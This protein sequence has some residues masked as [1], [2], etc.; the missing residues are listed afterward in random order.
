MKAAIK[1]HKILATVYD[2][3]ALLY[4]HVNWFKRFIRDVRTLKMILEV[5]SNQMLKMCEQMQKL[6]CGT[7]KWL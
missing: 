1:T 4:E 6:V 2:N 7:I 3:E 5:G